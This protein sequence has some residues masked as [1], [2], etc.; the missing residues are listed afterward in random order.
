VPRV[1]RGEPLAEEDVAEVAAA[2]RAL[3]LNAGAVRIGQPLYR[4]G[5]LIV[6]GRPPAVGVELVRGAVELGFAAPA[7]VRAGLVEVVVL[8]A[9]RRLRALVLD[10]VSLLGRELVVRR[11]VDGASTA[12]LSALGACPQCTDG[13]SGPGCPRSPRGY[14][15]AARAATSAG[16]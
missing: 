10:D 15:V 11:A 12:S 16:V 13:R 14:E 6:K 4:A 8:A 1:L 2:A 7:A 9:E 3:D 5:D